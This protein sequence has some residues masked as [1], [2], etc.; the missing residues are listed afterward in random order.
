M[1]NLECELEKKFI[2]KEFSPIVFVSGELVP[3]A[4]LQMITKQIHFSWIAWRWFIVRFCLQKRQKRIANMI[5]E[6]GT[7]EKEKKENKMHNFVCI[8]DMGNGTAVNGANGGDTHMRSVCVCR[9]FD[10]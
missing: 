2:R 6:H 5:S 9:R 7:R 3:L 4:I 8:S 10:L 1:Q